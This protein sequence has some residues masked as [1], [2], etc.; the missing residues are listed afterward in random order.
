MKKYKKLLNF[1]KK[2]ILTAG[3]RFSDGDT[4][5]KFRMG[6]TTFLAQQYSTVQIPNEEFAADFEADS[7]YRFMGLMRDYEWTEALDEAVLSEKSNEAERN[8]ARHDCLP[9]AGWS[10]CESSNGVGFAIKVGHN[11]E[12]HNH[13]DV[14]SFLNVVNEEQLICDL[15]A[16]E[17]TAEYFGKG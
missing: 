14:G 17:Y 7:C 4:N 6:L 3:R 8:Y 2:C 15:G 13:N 11:G 5:A 1:S 10:I 16:G 9:H 12:P